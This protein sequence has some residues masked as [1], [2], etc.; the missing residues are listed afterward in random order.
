M[1]ITFILPHAGLSGGTRVIAIYAKLLKARGHDVYVISQPQR[2]MQFRHKVRSFL[3]GSGWPRSEKG[4][5]F[6]DVPDINHS[7]LECRRAVTDSDV[8]D[9]DVV[10]ATWWETAEWVSSLS[11]GKGRKFYFIQDF[12]V[13]PYLPVDRVKA[14]YDLPFNRIAVSNWV[15][16]MVRQQSGFDNVVVVPNAVDTNQFFAPPRHKKDPITIGF[17]Y[18]RSPRKNCALAIQA[19]SRAKEAWPT[20]RAVSFG[21]HEPETTA[22]MPSWID[23]RLRPSQ[24]EIPEIYASADAWLF[25]SDSEGFGLP[26]LEAMACGTPVIATSAGAAPE[27]VNGNNGALVE[28]DPDRFAEHILK[29]CKMSAEDWQAASDAAKD[30]ICSYNWNNA[31]ELLEI[32]LLKGIKSADL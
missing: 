29:I 23:F 6:L 27:L 12:E 5:H 16:E 7:V 8:P 4:S 28:S 11:P 25:T 15:A 9:A 2:S 10:I 21:S 18:A 22:A 14:T 31:T 17:L 13:F 30:S 1:K 19:L 3:K 26:I 24:T 32:E 20:L